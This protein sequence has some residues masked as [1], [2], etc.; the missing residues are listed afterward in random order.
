MLLAI[1]ML[2]ALQ[3][4]EIRT[5]SDL[6]I[7]RFDEYTEG[8]QLPVPWVSA[9]L[10]KSVVLELTSHAES[11]LV[12]NYFTGKGVRLVDHSYEAG[13]G[14]G[15]GRSFTAP[16]EGDVYLGF[17]FRL[18]SALGA[19]ADLDLLVQLSDDAA[20]GISLQLS[21]KKGLSLIDSAGQSQEVY[22]KVEAGTW[23][24]VGVTFREDQTADF[25]LFTAKDVKVPFWTGTVDCSLGHLVTHLQFLSANNEVQSTGIWE[26]DN[27]SMAGSVFADRSALLPFEPMP[28]DA[29]VQTKKKVFCYYY[30]IYSSGYAKVDP[31]MSW[32]LRTTMNPTIKEDVRRRKAG[33]KI[34]YFPLLRPPMAED[35]PEDEVLLRRAMDEIRLAKQMGLDGFVVDFFYDP[36][37]GH[38]LKH[39]NN[40]SFALVDAAPLVDPHFKI[41]PAVYT[42][43][44]TNEQGAADARVDFDAYI[45]CEVFARL[46]AAE[47]V[48]RLKDG[49]M[50]FT[51]WFPER[52][53]A[54][55]WQRSLDAFEAKGMHMAFMTE[56]NTKSHIEEYAPFTEV[57]SHWGPRTPVEFNWIKQAR[58]HAPIVAAPI[59]SHDVRSRG[60]MY[61]E[62]ANYATLLKTWNT[63]MDED[64]DWAIIN[65]WSDYSEQA[66]APSTTIGFSLH[67]LNTYYTQWFK[68]GEQ[69]VITRDVLYYSYRIHHS[70]LEPRYGRKYGQVRR[71]QP[72]IEMYSGNDIEL[73]GFLKEPGDLVIRIDGEEHR[74]A[75]NAGIHSFR[76]PL[77]EGKSFMPEFSLERSGVPVVSGQGNHMVLDQ[78][79]F[80]N[81]LY[82][83]GVI[84]AK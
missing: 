84:P 55:F 20:D 31:G 69:P 26:V 43:A 49:R 58:P 12:N 13:V 6:P 22:G 53:T 24:H 38:G 21:S 82:H 61:W 64:A 8:I 4:I 9:G 70:D 79:E 45:N 59:A 32:Y 72:E 16:P 76:I 29:L 10:E 34:F 30:P 48:Y 81:L 74:M 35:V 80:P 47:G 51:I 39:F 52:H 50:L 2:G 46:Y 37:K 7:E 83:S 71:S 62:S 56:F 19:G 36:E 27:I 28:Y 1:P 11:D 68:T 75:A 73:L 33:T 54:A 17:D 18:G 44:G 66:M 42:Q 67:D 40:V 60:P 77:P 14:A 65:T 25:S 78:I 3:A 15:F 63:A 5:A 57:M 23:Y 41:I